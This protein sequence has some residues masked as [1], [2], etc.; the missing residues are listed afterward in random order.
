MQT[1]SAAIFDM[2][3][4]LIDSERTIMN[5]WLTVGRDLGVD[6]L[7]AEYLRIVGKAAQECHAILTDL[8]GG[9]AIFREALTRVRQ[10]L[11][12][13]SERPLF[14]LKSGV[15]SLLSM[16]TRAGIPCAV[17]SSSAKHEI[18][19]RLAQVGVLHFFNAI[20]GGDEVPRGKP[21]PAVYDLAAKRLNKSPAECLAFE[22]SENGVRA[23]NAAGIA[24]VTVPDL[25]A[26][27]DE[28]VERSFTVLRKL[29]EAIGQATDWFGI[30]VLSTS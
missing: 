18:Q 20:A 9:E 5:A 16:L 8:L 11:A 15:R 24:V 4:L 29:D 27:T 2:D 6:I 3:G 12:A 10:D 26:P 14:P 19:S 13:P 30:H 1:F 7:P 17:A 22:D 25:K 28:V 21:D 23:A